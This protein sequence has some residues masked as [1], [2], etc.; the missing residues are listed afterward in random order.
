[1]RPVKEEAEDDT[2]PSP[3]GRSFGKKGDETKNQ[4]SQ[5]ILKEVKF[6]QAF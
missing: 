4:A 3:A 2:H 6:E 5:G 1:M